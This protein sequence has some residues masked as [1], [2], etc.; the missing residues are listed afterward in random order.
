MLARAFAERLH[1]Y[2]ED[3]RL[4]QRQLALLAGVDPVQVSHYERG[5]TLPAADI[6]VEIARVLQISVDALISGK[7]NREP[8]PPLKNSL[9]LQR[10][11]DLDK[12]DRRHQ[13]TVIDV[14]DAMIARNKLEDALQTR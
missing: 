9:L 6:L 12:L 8:E 14:I 4:S 10:L 5:R 1:C 3:R 2:R 13:Q 11:Q 7:A